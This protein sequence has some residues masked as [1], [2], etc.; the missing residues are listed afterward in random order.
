MFPQINPFF[1]FS[2]LLFS[3]FFSTLKAS[4]RTKCDSKF[5]V[6]FSLSLSLLPRNPSHVGGG[7]GGIPKA[8]KLMPHIS[9]EK[10]KRRS[11]CVWEKQEFCVCA[12]ACLPVPASFT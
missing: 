11:T 5:L 12:P 7:G 8:P 4:D 6:S 3:S 1:L 10:K 2:S 9:F